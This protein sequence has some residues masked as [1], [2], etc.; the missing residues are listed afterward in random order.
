MHRELHRIGARQG[1]SP[2]QV[3]VVF[4]R[5]LAMMMPGRREH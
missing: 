1:F 4:G 3:D 5:M 2:E